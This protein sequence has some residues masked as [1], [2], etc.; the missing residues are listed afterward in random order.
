MKINSQSSL[1]LWSLLTIV[2]MSSCN[3]TFWAKRAQSPDSLTGIQDDS[4]AVSNRIE[5]LDTANLPFLE[6]RVNIHIIPDR[7]GNFLAGGPE[8]E[9]PINGLEYGKRLINHINSIYRDFKPSPTSRS[10]FVGDSRFRVVLYT[11]PAQPADSFGG[12]FYWNTYREMKGPYGDTVLNIL[13]RENGVK[14]DFKL[15]GSAC[16][17]S[18]DGCNQITMW[19]AYDNMANGGNFGWWSF[20]SNAVH[21]IGHLMGLCHS[22]YC[23]NECR[24]LDLDLEAECVTNP[25]FDDCGGPNI[26]H[27]DNWHSGSRNVMGYN[28]NNDAMTPCQW[29]T[30]YRNVYF[31]KAK[32]IR[33]VNPDG[34]Y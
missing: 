17:F 20:A 16:G 33:K 24:D 3:R 10:D 21:E 11:D 13:L 2:W 30:A 31:S 7:H 12:V 6:I 34:S 4:L 26:K 5:T 15:N 25:C 9:R 28:G 18:M 14:G 19:D 8:D 27:C 32:Y 22:F 23:Q 1:I 29:K